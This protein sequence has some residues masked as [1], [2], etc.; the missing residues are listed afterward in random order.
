M[1]WTV[2]YS[3]LFRFGVFHSQSSSAKRS[4]VSFH[5]DWNQ[6]GM[7]NVFKNT[8][9]HSQFRVTNSSDLNSLHFVYWFGT[10]QTCLLALDGFKFLILTVATTLCLG[11]NFIYLSKK[12]AILFLSVFISLIGR[13]TYF[14]SG[15]LILISPILRS[16]VTSKLLTKS[17]PKVNWSESSGFSTTR[18]LQLEDFV[19][20]PA[21]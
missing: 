7:S 1:S 8:L 13:L 14:F 4:Q 11:G 17:R 18:I 6:H 12:V 15:F 2:L 19:V 21:T 5:A 16:I 3:M 9:R 10:R 20:H